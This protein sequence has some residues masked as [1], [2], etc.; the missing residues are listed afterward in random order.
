MKEQCPLV[1]PIRHSHSITDNKKAVKRFSLNSLKI[2]IFF[3]YYPQNTWHPSE[4]P[5]P[6]VRMH[7]NQDNAPHI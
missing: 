2:K 3:I 6:Q 7:H 5:I 1:N 4:L